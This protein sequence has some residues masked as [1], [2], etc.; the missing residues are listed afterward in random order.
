MPPG[1]PDRQRDHDGKRGEDQ[2]VGGMRAHRHRWPSLAAVFACTARVRSLR[3]C[4]APH[5]PAPHLICRPPWQTFPGHL[6]W[7]QVNTDPLT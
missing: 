7:V 4:S 6:R 3:M 2:P 5:S 1:I